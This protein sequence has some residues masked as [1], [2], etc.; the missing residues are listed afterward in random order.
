[1]AKQI[2]CGRNDRL[3]RGP[4]PWTGVLDRRSESGKGWRVE[5]SG[6]EACSYHARGVEVVAMKPVF[7]GFGK[8]SRNEV[9]G[10]LKARQFSTGLLRFGKDMFLD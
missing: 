2:T 7:T 6:T 5:N 9:F 10:M 3:A 8:P 1:M 4:R